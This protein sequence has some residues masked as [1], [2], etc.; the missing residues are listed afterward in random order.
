MPYLSLL[1]Y[2][3]AATMKTVFTTIICFATIIVCCQPTISLTFD[4]GI[5]HD[6]SGYKFEDWNQM[7]LDALAKHDLQAAFFVTGFN[8]LDQKGKYLLRSWD[9]AGH[10]IGNHT[11]S[12]PNFNN[13]RVGM[14]EF[15]EEF[16]GT[17][18]L[19]NQLDHFVKLFRFPFLKEGE[20]PEEV[21]AIRSFLRGQGYKNGYVTV[22]A[23]D[24]YIDSRLRKRL[25]NNP[26]A[27]LDPFKKFYLEHLF[28]RANYYEKLSYDMTGRHINHTLLLHHNLTSALFLDD[29]IKMFKSN[30]W[31]VISAEEAYRDPIFDQTPAY[32]GESLIWAL[33]KDSGLFTEQL[34]YP[35]EDSRYEKKRMDDLGL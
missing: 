16:I 2:I 1:I 13:T 8:K 15:K 30:G 6:R 21:Q 34:R 4:D 5:T 31:K 7:I 17:D 29:L 10:L 19:I 11:F 9:N 24:W 14:R 26:D 3:E 27:P 12:H 28:E 32:A 23:S 20:T 35:A 33:A 22:D 25:S 18:T